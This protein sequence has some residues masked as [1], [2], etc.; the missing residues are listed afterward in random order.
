MEI[1]V[2]KS[3][4]PSQTIIKGYIL[5]TLLTLALIMFGLAQAAPLANLNA[6]DPQLDAVQV[7]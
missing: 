4:T 6:G 7:N 1:T 2:D 5:F 3:V